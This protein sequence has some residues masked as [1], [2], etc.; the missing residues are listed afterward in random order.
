MDV[1]SGWRILGVEAAQVWKCHP[2]EIVI[3]GRAAE[4]GQKSAYRTIELN[5]HPFYMAQRLSFD[6]TL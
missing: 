5:L 2:M 6:P 3:I 1:P 4:C